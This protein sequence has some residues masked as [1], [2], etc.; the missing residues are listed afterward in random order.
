M[1]KL[2]STPK[3]R[4]SPTGKLR[5][6]SAPKGHG[7]AVDV[8]VVDMHV[9][10]PHPCKAVNSY[11]CSKAASAEKKAAGAGSLSFLI[12]HSSLWGVRFLI[13][14]DD[15]PVFGDYYF[16]ICQ[17]LVFVVDVIDGLFLIAGNYLFRTFLPSPS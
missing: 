1:P 3:A 2:A 5:L 12:A 7:A 9:V 17:A 13:F 11:P 15:L 8:F 6:A 14:M 4:G 16:L 10:L